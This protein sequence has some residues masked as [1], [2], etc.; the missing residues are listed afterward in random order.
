MNKKGKLFL[1]TL[2]A[3]SVI[4]AV[5]F[6]SI[7]MATHVVTSPNIGTFTVL[8]SNFYNISVNNTDV[9]ASNITQVNITLPPTFMFLNWTNQTDV[10]AASVFTNLSQ[11]TKL[12]WENVTGGLIANLTRNY[13]S[14]NATASTIGTYNITVT[15]VNTTNDVSYTNISV[16]INDPTSPV[17]KLIAPANSTN[18]TVGTLMFNASF[19]DN[20]ALLNSSLFL[21]NSTFDTVNISNVTAIGTK[22]DT[23]LTFAFPYEGRFYW[24]FRAEDSSGNLAFN[25]TNRTILYDAT[26]P[27]LTYNT[28]T[29]GNVTNISRANIVVNVTATET[30]LQSTNITLFNTTDVVNSSLAFSSPSFINFT[31]VRDGNYTFNATVLDY[32]GNTGNAS[33][34]IVIVDTVLPIINFT[35]TTEINNSFLSKNNIVV[36]ITATDI[37]LKNITIYVY[38]SSWTNVTI[39]TS[40]PAFVNVTGLSDGN[41]SFNSTAYDYAGNSNTTEKRT[42]MLDT[43]VSLIAYGNGVEGNVT[44]ISR[45]NIVVNVT[46]TDI[47]LRN[48]TINLYNITGVVVNTSTTTS[49]PNY[50]NFTNLRDGNYT[51]NATSHDLADNSNFTETRIV[52]VDTIKPIINFTIQTVS[53]D[54]VVN[55]SFFINVTATDVNLRNVNISVYN[56]SWSN[57]SMTLAGSAVG[58]IAFINYTGLADGLY[59]FNATAFDYAGN[60]NSTTTNSSTGTRNVTFET[61]YP[62]IS[63]SADTLATGINKSQT[64]IYVNV[65]VVEANEK[66]ITFELYNATGLVNSTVFTTAQRIINWTGLPNQN[67]TYNVSIWDKGSKQNSTG[68]RTITLDTAA[69]STDLAKASSTANS[70]TV[71]LSGSDERSGVSGAC[72]L[73]SSS[74]TVSSLTISGLN[75]GNSYTITGNCTD[76]AG[77]SGT[78]VQSLST[79]G[80]G[81]GAGTGSGSRG[82]IVSKW[83]KEIKLNGS[84]LNLGQALKELKTN[85]R[86]TFNVS[87]LGHYLGI[88]NITNTSVT[89]EVASTP[90]TATL[91][92]GETKKFE[93]TGDNNY[94]ISVT[95]VSISNGQAN[96]TMKSISE[97]VVTTTPQATGNETAPPAAEGTSGRTLWIIIVVVVVV[98]IVIFAIYLFKRK[99]Y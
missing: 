86:I 95:L 11:I 55:G 10:A 45:T 84:E 72:V 36:N 58:D 35:I 5:V 92:V 91:S 61:L 14:F 38:N 43:I 51:F 54:A 76:Y 31:N 90:Q 39:W 12:S 27:L 32:A 71:T 66:N 16:T 96:I 94:D 65:T 53:S 73:T 44:N 34:R 98:L 17:V 26:R 80:C 93:I 49:S 75:C 15:T 77:N 63:F 60:S 69:P 48:I 8:V 33:T 20:Y 13:F 19:T 4:L 24:N 56:S 40:S 25:N 68:S 1:K 89:V 41:Y 37:N 9:T 85:Y 64:F 78:S 2:L 18:T 50:I 79:D 7:V 46:A 6:L 87:G 62:Q 28:N 23:N 52:I 59:Y 70:I 47:N 21:Y 22:N 57:S 29:E 82:S 81:S 30:N 42:I 74:G 88:T 97:P 3:V 67:Y 83:V 99:K